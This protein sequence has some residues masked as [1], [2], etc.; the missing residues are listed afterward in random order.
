MTQ[1]KIADTSVARWLFLITTLLTLIGIIFVF[2]SSINESYRTF[3]T[4][5]ALVTQQLIGIGIGFAAFVVATLLPSR[6]WNR[7]GPGLYFF[8]I[9]LLT[10]VFAPVIGLKLNGARRWLDLGFMVI[11]PV[12]I[13]KFALIVGFAHWFAKKQRLRPFMLLAAIPIGLLLLQPDLGSALLLSTIAVGMFFL[14]GGSVKKLALLSLVATPLLVMAVL[15]SA[16]RFERV[17]TFLNP[18]GDVQGAG[19]HVAQIS[20]AFG[21]GGW[22]GRGIGNSQQKLSYLPESSTDSIF[23]IVGEEIG[24]VGTFVV[25]LLFTLLF[26]YLYRAA[27]QLESKPEQQ[28]LI[29]GILLWF[30]GQTFLNLL[31]TVGLIPLTGEPLPF[32]SYGRSSLIMLLFASGVAIRA[33][34]ESA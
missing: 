21:R 11:Q 27:G 20:L 10:L 13:M 33:T 3:G 32:F 16:Y 15:A 6:I 24:F 34:R 5:Y 29:Y 25:V 2:E 4:P 17:K 1:K 23:A 7:F 22:F 30:A 19:F 26:F 28:L 18:S 12:E 8:G 14:A 9:V 31:S